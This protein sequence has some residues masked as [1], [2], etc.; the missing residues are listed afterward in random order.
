MGNSRFA[1]FFFFFII[2]FFPL[3]GRICECETF[4]IV[5]SSFG[6]YLFLRDSPD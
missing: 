3:I 6:F 1:M 4:G 5:F 2:E